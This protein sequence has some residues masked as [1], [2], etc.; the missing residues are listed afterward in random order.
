MMRAGKQVNPLRIPEQSLPLTVEGMAAQ[1]RYHAALLLDQRLLDGTASAQEVSLAL[2]YD[3]EMDELSK[4]EVRARTKK[5][6]SQTKFIEDQSNYEKQVAEALDAF[7]SY[8]SS[9]GGGIC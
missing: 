2:R 4:G 3:P 5:I 8:R 1:V 9:A 6:E 7:K